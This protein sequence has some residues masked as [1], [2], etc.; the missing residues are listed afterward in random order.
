MLLLLVIALASA[1]ALIMPW[2]FHIGNRWTPLLTWWGSGRLVTKS[3]AEYPLFVMLYPSSS[4]SR[5]R[6]DGQ[7]PT[8]G[9][10]GSGCLCTSSEKFEYLRLSGTLYGGW[11]G[12]DGSLMN[13]RLLEPTIVNIGQPQA[14]YFDLIGRWEGS[15]LVM[16]ERAAWSRRFRDGL[17]V[18][19]VSVTLHWNPYWTCKSACASAANRAAHVASS[20]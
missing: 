15:D 6:L 18:E 11:S 20:R 7:R 3:G 10:R 14:G 17:R 1:A 2:A 19:R 4:F 9:V 5:L 8:G 13:I 12:T 16:D